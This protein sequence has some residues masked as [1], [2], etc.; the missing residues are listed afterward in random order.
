MFDDDWLRAAELVV[1][2]WKLEQRHNPDVRPSPDAGLLLVF[3]SRP[4]ADGSARQTSPYKYHSEMAKR[5]VGADAGYTG[6]TWSGSLS[7]VSCRWSVL[8]RVR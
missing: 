8:C 3:Q 5:G 1:R 6:M 2:T 7:S 4:G